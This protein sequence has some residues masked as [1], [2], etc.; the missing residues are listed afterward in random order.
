MTVSPR[1]VI[2]PAYGTTSVSGVRSP[3]LCVAPSDFSSIVVSPP[4]MLPGDGWVPDIETERA[5]FRF[6]A[7]DDPESWAAGS[8]DGPGGEQMFGAHDLRD[9]QAPRALRNPRADP[10]RALDWRQADVVGPSAL[11]HGSASPN[12]R[13]HASLLPAPASGRRDLVPLVVVRTVPP[14]LDG[15]DRG[16]S[17]GTRSAVL[18]YYLFAAERHNQNGTDVGCA[19]V[20]RKIA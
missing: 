4:R 20:R 17:G 13:G 9:L 16:A 11:T 14:C 19:Q 3:P 12:H 1:F 2:R 5:C 15:D 6:D 8:G 18:G 7:A 10:R